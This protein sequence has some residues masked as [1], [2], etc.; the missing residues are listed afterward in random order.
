MFLLLGHNGTITFCL[1]LVML[2][3]ISSFNYSLIGENLGKN[4]QITSHPEN[5]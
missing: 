3:C 2:I 1:S 4:G 5:I